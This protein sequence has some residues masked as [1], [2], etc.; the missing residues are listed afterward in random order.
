MKFLATLIALTISGAAAFSA[1]AP[2]TKVP[3]VELDDGFVGPAKG[4]VAAVHLI[5]EAQRSRADAVHAARE[6]DA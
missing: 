6:R 2:G 1:I 5:R 4:Q 3:A